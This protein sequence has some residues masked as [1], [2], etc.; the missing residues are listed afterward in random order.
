MYT[1]LIYSQKFLEC[2]PQICFIFMIQSLFIWFL[3]IEDEE[4]HMKVAQKDNE[5]EDKKKLR[6]ETRLKNRNIPGSFCMAANSPKHFSSCW[7][8]SLY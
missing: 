5:K 4:Q 7:R 8:T 6:A 1:H 2:Q 3:S